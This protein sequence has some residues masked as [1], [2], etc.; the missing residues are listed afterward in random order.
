MA[1]AALVV[2]D[3]VDSPAA[4]NMARRVTMARMLAFPF[5]RAVPAIAERTASVRAG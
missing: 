2:G 4:F 3:T 1:T 5:S